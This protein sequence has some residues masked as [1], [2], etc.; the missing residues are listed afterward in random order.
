MLVTSSNDTNIEILKSEKSDNKK[1]NNKYSIKNQIYCK[2]QCFNA[3][4]L[5]DASHDPHTV[6][7]RI[8][9]LLLWREQCLLIC[10]PN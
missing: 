5:R 6:F 3:I 7:I 4:K 10:F 8:L 1:I 9:F 2:P